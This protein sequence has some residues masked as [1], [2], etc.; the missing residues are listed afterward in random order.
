MLKLLTLMLLPMLACAQQ[1]LIRGRIID[2]ASGEPVIA[3]TI[4]I[5]GS[6][7]GAISNDEGMFQLS[8]SKGKVVA[9]SSIGYKSIELPA[10]SFDSALTDIRLEP[11]NKILE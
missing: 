3:A 2:T 10:E 11:D 6:Y 9:I 5:K 1:F 4:A 8:A 7:M